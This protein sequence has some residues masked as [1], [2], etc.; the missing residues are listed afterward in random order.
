MRQISADWLSVPPQCFQSAV[1]PSEPIDEKSQPPDPIAMRSDRFGRATLTTFA[2]KPENP[3]FR[4]GCSRWS[5]RN[6]G[7]PLGVRDSAYGMKRAVAAT[8]SR[9]PLV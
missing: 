4:E 8:D 7:V 6:A 3:R 2:C 5:R 1:D 9:N